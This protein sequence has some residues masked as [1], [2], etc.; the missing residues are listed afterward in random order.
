MSKGSPEVAIMPPGCSWEFHSGV[1]GLSE[2]LCV[3][4][5]GMG[6][7]HASDLLDSEVAALADYMIALW[8]RSRD[9]TRAP[10]SVAFSHVCKIEHP[11]GAIRRLSDAV[12][13]IT[14]TTVEPGT[15]AINEIVHSMLGH[16]SRMDDLH[17]A[18][19][20]LHH[21]NRDQFE[22]DGWPDNKPETE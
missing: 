17:S 1:V 22:T 7:G 18:L 15:S 3:Y 11:L 4:D 13:L 19:F 14:E 8:T 21:P 10:K 9:E 12:A 16:V 20:R 5:G 6:V 2:S